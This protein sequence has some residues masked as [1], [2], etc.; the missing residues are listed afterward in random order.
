MPDMTFKEYEDGAVSTAIYPG[1]G[2]PIGLMY[3]ALKGAGEAGEF[4]EH[5]GKALR[6]DDI[7]H[8]DNSR[9]PWFQF[10]N[11]TDDRRALLRKEVGDQLWY[12]AAKARE[13]GTSLSDIAAENLA[14][15]ADRKKR[16]VLGGSGDTR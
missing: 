5:V 16:G 12:L 7:V 14:K 3:V 2:T 8:S 11:L 10:D 13:L 9:Q 1:Q 15:L 6:D 4:A